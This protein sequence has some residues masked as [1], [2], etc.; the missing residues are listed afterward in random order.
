MKLTKLSMS[1]L[2]A[3]YGKSLT[4]K[5]R[6]SEGSVGLPNNLTKTRTLAMS[7][8]LQSHMA[9]KSFPGLH[10]AFLLSPE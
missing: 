8:L 10:D 6:T 4:T 7:W 5:R 1:V 3:L 9:G 2:E